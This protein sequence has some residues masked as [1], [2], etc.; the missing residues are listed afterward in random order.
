MSNTLS[1]GYSPTI[2]WPKHLSFGKNSTFDV[3]F[4]LMGGLPFYLPLTIILG[5]AFFAK[6]VPFDWAFWSNQIVSM[7]H[8]WATYFRLTRKIKEGK[9]HY[10]YGLPAYVSIVAFLIAATMDGYFLQVMTAVN[11]WQSYHYCRQTYGVGRF[12]ARP[13]GETELERKLTFWAYHAAMPIFILGRWNMLYIFWKG[14]PSDA[15]IPVGFPAPLLNVLWVLAAVGLLVGLYNEILKYRRAHGTFDC[16]G[17][18]NL[19]VYYGMHWYGFVSMANYEAGFIAITIFHAMQY[20]A[21][22]WRLEER[23]TTTPFV[24]SKVFK[25]LP[26]LASFGLFWIILYLVGD[27]A[28]KYV[29]QHGNVFLPQFAMICLSSVSAHHYLVDTMLWSKKTGI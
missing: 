10:L 9:I 23:Q 25:G 20:L 6:N 17:L 11:V 4:I 1:A 15:I 29:F 12:F 13:S 26:V 7:P 3:L 22:S 5:E 8:V 19:I 21:I 28:E 18:V 14:K 2:K 27:N 16:S 24:W